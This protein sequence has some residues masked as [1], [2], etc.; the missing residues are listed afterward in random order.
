MT[1]ILLA[2][3]V[4]SSCLFA[5]DI[6]FP[7]WVSLAFSGGLL[8]LLLI[9]TGL[10]EAVLSKYFILLFALPF[11]HG[12]E[13]LG[14]DFT[15]SVRP[16]LMWGL[17]TNPYTF[18]EPII[19]RMLM[20]GLIG[21]TGLI[22]FPLYRLTPKNKVSSTLDRYKGLN[23]SRFVA[24]L[25]IAFLLSWLNTPSQSIFTH[26]YGSGGDDISSFNFNASWLL[27]YILLIAIF[28]DQEFMK[29][30][31]R[32]LTIKRFLSIGVT[33]YIVIFHQFFRGD[34]EC[35]T[36]IFGIMLLYLLKW[37][38]S[39]KERMARSKKAY[40]L[41][42]FFIFISFML[43]VVANLVGSVRSILSEGAVYV[44]TFAAIQIS[45]SRV[46][47]GTWSGVL[48]SPLS[49]AGDFYLGHMSPRWGSTYLDMLLSLIPSPLAR[50]FDYA[51]PLDSN[52]GPAWDMRYGI[53]GTH[54]LV[55]PYMNFG[56][57]GV[58]IVALL[59]G[60]FFTWLERSLQKDPNFSRIF[61][62][63]SFIVVGPHW[64]WYGDMSLIRG[65]MAFAI[66]WCLYCVLALK[67]GLVELPRVF[68]RGN[69]NKLFL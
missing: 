47:A 38:G 13:Y 55:V 4:L 31:R 19:S 65:L 49:V 17:L 14:F 27:A 20:L 6:I 29:V 37:S 15:R 46:Y 68:P 52:V 58:L 21:L 11:I 8:G 53:G 44:D 26:S 64:Y 32:T 12:F 9:R 24:M 22:T 51:R 57:I 61:L 1:Y 56:S 54:A 45:L 50:L 39:L 16:H 59:H 43:I 42:A 48:L 67:P 35:I 30:P 23:L 33:F 3:G 10:F 41:P 62:F 36:L 18:S 34:R 5:V 63:G 69:I 25:A 60:A 7:I 28:V 40:I 2:F 66:S